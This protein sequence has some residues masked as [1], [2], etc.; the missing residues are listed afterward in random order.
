MNGSSN[1]YIDHEHYARVG[2]Q[3][4]AREAGKLFSSLVSQ[5]KKT[6]FTKGDKS[7]SG[8]LA[9]HKC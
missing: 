5:F 1:S 7:A 4:Q 2:R 8:V 6:F 3:M 9:G